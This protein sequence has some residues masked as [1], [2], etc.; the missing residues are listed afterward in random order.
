MLVIPTSLLFYVKDYTKE[1]YRIL[2]ELSFSI[3]IYKTSLR[4]AIKP[5]LTRALYNNVL[6]TSFIEV[7][8]NMTT[9]VGFFLSCDIS[10]LF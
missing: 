4:T 6:G 2:H 8:S 3:N 1:V 9:S 5:S 7:Y 10:A